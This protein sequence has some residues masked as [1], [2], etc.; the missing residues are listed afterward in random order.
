MEQN[1]LGLYD[2][3]DTSYV[4]YNWSWVYI[5]I[6]IFIFLIIPLIVYYFRYKKRA[7]LTPVQKAFKK[8]SNLS[9]EHFSTPEQR[10]QFY[11]SLSGILKEFLHD[12]FEF[13]VIALTDDELVEYL[14]DKKKLSQQIEAIKTVTS[15]I[16]FIKFAGVEAAQNKMVQDLKLLEEVIVKSASVGQEGGKK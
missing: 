11:F 2:I 14:S 7:K 16:T 1:E 13:D 3:Y 9:P 8:I 5:S 10:K 4:P 6:L 15:G 12:Q